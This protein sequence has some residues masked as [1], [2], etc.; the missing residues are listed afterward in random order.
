[1]TETP[2]PLSRIRGHFDFLRCRRSIHISI[3]FF[4]REVRLNQKSIEPLWHT[5]CKK[6]GSFNC[7]CWFLFC[8]HFRFDGNI[9]IFSSLFKYWFMNIVYMNG[10]S[11]VPRIKNRKYPDINC[12]LHHSSPPEQQPAF[13][14]IS[15]A[16]NFLFCS[17]APAN[18]QRFSFVISAL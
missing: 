18:R 7:V 13:N 15:S 12:S 3:H 9:R 4:R 17:V 14:E 6:K 10:K 1:M 11:C 2:H 16:I 5:G 8:F